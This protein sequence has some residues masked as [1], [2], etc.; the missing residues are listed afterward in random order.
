VRAGGTTVLVDSGPDLRMKALREGIRELDAIVYTHAHL[1]HNDPESLEKL[2]LTN[3]NILIF[4]PESVWA[5]LKDKKSIS[6][7]LNILNKNYIKLNDDLEV[8]IIPAA[9]LELSFTNNVCLKV[10]VMFFKHH[11]KSSTTRVIQFHIPK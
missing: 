10:L 11:I 1:D 8:N 5:I 2:I 9:H 6:R 3:P 7:H 4:G